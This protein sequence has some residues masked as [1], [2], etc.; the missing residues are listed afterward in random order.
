M[1]VIK[2]LGAIFK[3][4]NG[5][6]LTQIVQCKKIDG[7]S[8]TIAHADTTNMDTAGGKQTFTPTLVDAGSI[9]LDIEYDP[10]DVMH[11]AL[12]TDAEAKTTRT[13]Q[14]TE[15]DPSPTTKDG[16]GF[17]SSIGFTRD[18]AGVLMLNVTIKISGAITHV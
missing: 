18:F 16:S 17:V 9:T 5:T 8:E 4:H 14:I 10:D 3:W 1:A 15:T 13:W 2:A 6:A 11:K 12:I 7:P